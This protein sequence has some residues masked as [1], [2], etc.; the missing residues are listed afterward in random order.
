VSLHGDLLEQAAHLAKRETKRPKQ[1]SLRR[2]VSTAY[3]ALFHLL[4][5]EA[6]GRLLTGTSRAHMKDVVARAFDHAEMN[7]AASQFAKGTPDRKVMALLGTS[8]VSPDLAAVAR[9]FVDLQEFRHEA[10]YNV[11][12]RFTRVEAN[13]KVGQA[14]LAFEAWGRVR[15]T[16][17]ADSFLVA[18]LV[19][20]KVRV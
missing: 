13:D 9:T 10:D 11:G 20:R 6:T 15:G 3:Y 17:A 7:A 16:G 2:S 4:V 12:R 5:S 1:A 14:R 19:Y 18:L 8:V